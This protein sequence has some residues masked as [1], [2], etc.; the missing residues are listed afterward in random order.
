MFQINRNI[1]KFDKIIFD[2]CLF[3][4]IFQYWRCLF[5]TNMNIFRH[6]KLEIALAIP[7]SNEWKTQTNNSAG[8]GLTRQSC[9]QHKAPQKNLYV[10][11]LVQQTILVF[12]LIGLLTDSARHSAA[13]PEAVW[14]SHFSTTAVPSHCQYANFNYDKSEM[15]V[16]LLSIMLA[17]RQSKGQAGFRRAKIM[18]I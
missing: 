17:H 15:T 7:A 13:L 4:P 14:F 12:I 11:I 5:F 8:Q 3:D 16:I 10:D 2:R 18:L 9:W 6:L 1:N